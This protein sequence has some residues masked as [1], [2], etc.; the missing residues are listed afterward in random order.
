[1]LDA[2]RKDFQ[3]PETGGALWERPEARTTGYQ[4]SFPTAQLGLTALATGQSALADAV[5]GWYERM[6]TAQPALP[7]TL[8]PIWGP[9]GLV[10]E[11]PESFQFAA[12]VD[13]AKPL[14]AFYNPGIAAAFLARYASRT[15]SSRARR[16][17]VDFLTLNENGTDAQFNYWESTSVCKFGLGAAM[18]LDLTHEERYVRDVER[19]ARWYA[20]SQ[21][22]DGSWV[23]RTP[24]RPNPSEPHIMEKTA[25]HVLW[26]SMMLTSLAAHDAAAA[27]TTEEHTR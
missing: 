27:T 2:V 22:P 4:L 9:K 16:L 12:K 23:H 17:A 8:Y 5:F 15:G 3:H 14:Q 24:S 6:W 20:D 19:M 13:F 18:L 26:V 11:F 10:T 1:M 21:N 7:G 25:E